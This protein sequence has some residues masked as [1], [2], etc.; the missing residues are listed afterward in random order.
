MDDVS[1]SLGGI[2]INTYAIKGSVQKQGGQAWRGE[3]RKGR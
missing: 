3:E 1:M 2:I